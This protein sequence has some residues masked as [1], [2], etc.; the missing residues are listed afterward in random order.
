MAPVLDIIVV[1][2][3]AG[4]QLRVCLSSALAADSTGFR[5]GRLVVVDNGSTDGSADGIKALGPAVVPIRNPDNRG[6]A[7]ACNEGAAGSR[8]DYLL[9]LNPDM[10]LLSDSLVEPIAFL[11][12]PENAWVG[13]VGIQL[14]DEGGAVRRSCA[15]F[16]TAGRYLA[17]T[18]GLDRLAP[19]LFPP[20]FMVEWDHGD[21]RS[22]D[23]VMGAF[24]LVRH[25][26]FDRLTGFDERFFVYFEDVDFSL[27]AGREG[28]SS[29][30]L[31]AAR[32]YHFGAGTTEQA[33]ARRL[34]YN[35]RSRVL[36]GYKYFGAIQA[37][38]LLLATLAVEPLMRIAW[39]IA[40]AAPQEVK[41]TLMAYAMLFWALP[42]IARG[43][44]CEA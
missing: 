40:R 2:W 9:F 15:R 44:R 26:L 41:D 35:L 8:A 34:F 12:R 13:I 27:R 30:Y 38:L 25:S 17:T 19:R 22:V 32:A 11:E 14:L 18:L 5:L 28:W 4:E 43:V 21:N 33:K 20:H 42:E 39:A 24:F 16:P 36:Y 6:F 1:N 23:Q 29:V 37:T 31:A 3:N 10:R 7:A